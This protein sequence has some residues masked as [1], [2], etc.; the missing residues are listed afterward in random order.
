MSAGRTPPP[1]LATAGPLRCIGRAVRL[2]LANP[3][4]CPLFRAGCTPRTP[5][6]EGMRSQQGLC[7]IWFGDGEGQRSWDAEHARG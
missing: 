7:N 6:G 1:I 2:G 3:E 5:R 4:D